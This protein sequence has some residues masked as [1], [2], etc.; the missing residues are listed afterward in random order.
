VQVINGPLSKI[1]TDALKIVYDVKKLEKTFLSHL[2][3]SKKRSRQLQLK[4][5]LE[6][7]IMAGIFSGVCG[8]R[9]DAEIVM[10]QKFGRM[11]PVLT[12]PG[13][14]MRGA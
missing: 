11:A 6:E 3:Q 4:M 10:F 14:S 7:K 5:Y 1:F 2:P 13:R 9:A 8:L 12:T